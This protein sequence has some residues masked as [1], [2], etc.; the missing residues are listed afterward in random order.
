M[1]GNG[2]LEFVAQSTASSARSGQLLLAQGDIVDFLISVPLF[3]ST[4]T[5][6]R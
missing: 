5:V 4:A 1:I 3:N 2:P 6:H